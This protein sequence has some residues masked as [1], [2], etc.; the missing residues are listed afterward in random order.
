[1][2]SV[3]D[4]SRLS[5]DLAATLAERLLQTEI[6]ADRQR[7]DRIVQGALARLPAARAVTVRGHADDIALLDKQ[8]A[9]NDELSREAL[10]LRK[11][12]TLPR[13]RIVVEAGDFFVEWDTSKCL[14]E[15]RAALDEANLT[16]A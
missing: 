15:L 13:G 12:V 11:D 3:A 8:V 5:V 16:D 7:L 9:N 14:A 10:T 1:M 6:T 2:Q 4:L